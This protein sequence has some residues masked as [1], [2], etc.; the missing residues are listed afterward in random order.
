MQG[1]FLG[2]IYK[3]NYAFKMNEFLLQYLWKNALFNP[4]SLK[5]TE[6][7][8]VTVLH[9]GWQNSNE[10]PDFT[11]AKIKIGKTIWVGNVELHLRTSDWH[12]HGHGRHAAYRNII[13]HVVY[14]D[15]E[16]LAGTSFPTLE[17]KPYLDPAIVARYQQLMGLDKTIPCAAQLRSVPDIV[18]VTWLDRLLA[19]RLESRLDEWRLLWLQAGKDWRTLL[20]YRLAANFGFHVNR[21]AFLELAL[22]IPLNIL[23][24]HRKNLVQTEALLFGQSGLLTG[25]SPDDY[26]LELEKEYHFMR[27]KYQLIPLQPHRWK[28]MRLRPSNFPT[29]RIAQFAMLVHK[30]FDLFARMMEVKNEAEIMP[31][32]NVHA[33]A[34]WDNH[35]RLGEKA[36]EQQVKHLGG[37]AATNIMINTVAPMQYLYSRLQG[38]ASLHEDSL[39]LLQSLKPENNAVIREWKRLDV[40]VRNAAQSQA[41]LQL[42]HNYCSVKACL[43]CTVGSRLIRKG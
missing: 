40:E 30:S 27:R 33:S 28:F 41:L 36:R 25:D 7:E 26:M 11:E 6:R 21:E 43:N 31:L 23:S 5:T 14:E 24:R 16:P 42:F 9:P 15:D 34:Y 32:L 8:I 37:E 2:H 10:G 1:L 39:N 4:S 20:Y 19:E 17:L 38:K 13:L 22:S 3:A 18:W 12:K 35:Y 29:I